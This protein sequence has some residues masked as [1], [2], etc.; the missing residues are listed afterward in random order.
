MCQFDGD[1]IAHGDHRHGYV[2][3]ASASWELG[4]RKGAR[5]PAFASNCVCTCTGSNDI[6]ERPIEGLR[7]RGCR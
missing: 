2:G 4:L 5:L 6:G 1:L 7:G 3:L